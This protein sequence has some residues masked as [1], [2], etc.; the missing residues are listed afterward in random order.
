MAICVACG[1]SEAEFQSLKNENA[2]LQMQVDS[3]TLELNAYRYS[4]DKLL[5]D[6]QL[7]AKDENKEKVSTLLAQIQEY[8]PKHQNAKKYKNYWMKS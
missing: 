2:A 5:A 4:P 8:H 7:A 1:H 6:A 3:L